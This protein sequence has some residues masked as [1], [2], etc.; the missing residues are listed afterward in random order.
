MYSLLEFSVPLQILL[1]QVCTSQSVI[2]WFVAFVLY[3]GSTQIG[4]ALVV[5]DISC[6]KTGITCVYTC[7]P[8]G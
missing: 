1:P 5:L 6:V 4:S 8:I 7:N 3:V 2:F